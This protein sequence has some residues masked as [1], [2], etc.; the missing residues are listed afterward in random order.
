MPPSF[1][2]ACV[3]QTSVSNIKFEECGRKLVISNPTNLPHERVQVDGCLVTNGLRADWILARSGVASLVIELKGT[4]VGHA[5]SQV[6][7]TLAHCQAN[8]NLEPKVG[9]VIICQQVPKALTSV[10]RAADKFRKNYGA[11]LV[12]S[13]STHT[14]PLDKLVA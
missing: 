8:G 9:A 12:V 10:Q 3:E 5:L 2:P 7:A 6:E 14:F 11:R 13:S 4:D 1:T